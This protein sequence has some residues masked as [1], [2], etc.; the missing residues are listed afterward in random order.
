MDKIAIIG[1]GPAGISAA[2]YAV[3]AGAEAIVLGSGDSAL[4]KA[5]K[6]E[7]Y[8]GFPEAISGKELFDRGIK[9]AKRVGVELIEE[10]VVGIGYTTGLEVIAE[11]GKYDAGAIVIATG[12]PRITPKIE[13]IEK[14]EGKGVSYCAVCDG[15]FFKG[16]EVAI[17][18]NGKYALHEAMELTPVAKKVSILTDGLEPEAEI[19]EDIEIDKRKIRKLYGSNDVLNG[20]MFEDGENK[21]LSGLFIAVGTAGSADLA[22]KIGA[23]TDGIKIIVDENMATNVP[24]LFAAGDCIGG[25]KQISSSVYEGALAGLNAV[26][27]VKENGK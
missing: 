7:N 9:Q 5:E 18:G 25:L 4:L 10:E 3:R 11:K 12:S 13:G 21:D 26:K 17:V 22:K 16:L 1:N 2:I 24:G 15:F 19:P 20:V 23:A 6:I 14:Y 27:Y 8:Y